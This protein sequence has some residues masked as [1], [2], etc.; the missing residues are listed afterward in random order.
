MLLGHELRSRREQRGISREDAGSRIRASASK[1]SRMELGRVGFKLRDI[2]DLLKLYGA[3]RRTIKE[4]L[5]VA[6]ESNKP[7]WWKEYGD[8]LHKWLTHYIGFEEAAD[9]IRIYESQFIPGLLQTEEYA[10]EI[11]FGGVEADTVAEQ[12]LEARLKRQKRVETDDNMRMWVILD[13]AA[14]RRPIGATTTG[15]GVMRRQ[16]EHLIRLSTEKDNITIQIIPFAVGAHAAEAGSFTLLRYSDYELAD[17]VYLER[18]HDGELNDK[19]SVV[20][21]YTKAM[22]RL[23]VSAATPDQTLEMLKGI[24]EDFSV[25]GDGPVTPV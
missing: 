5:E 16:I 15:L 9:Q 18:L 19:R 14:V 11:I 22:T 3:D 23:S 25:S 10:R 13:E 8:S 12:R 2:E 7:G 24:L 21:A 17:M 4:M 20:E 6:K 1:I